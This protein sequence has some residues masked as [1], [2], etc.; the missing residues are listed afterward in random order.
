MR[1]IKTA[2]SE[3]FPPG[4]GDDEEN[5]SPERLASSNTTANMV[6][7]GGPASC[8]PRAPHVCHA[9]HRRPRRAKRGHTR[10]PRSALVAAARVRFDAE[11]FM[12]P[13]VVVKMEK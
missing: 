3:S 1:A 9:L 11:D 6:A 8:V 13:L 5:L 12:N 2:Y 4:S 7:R 10:S